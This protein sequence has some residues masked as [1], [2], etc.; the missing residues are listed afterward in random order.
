MRE[1]FKEQGTDHEIIGD[2]RVYSFTNN[3]KRKAIW[4]GSFEDRRP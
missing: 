3:L 4:H 1:V 2:T